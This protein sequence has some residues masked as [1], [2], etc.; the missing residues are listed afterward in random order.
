MFDRLTRRRR[1]V[2]DRGVT[3][4]ELLIAVLITGTLVTAMATATMVII[5]QNDNTEGRVNNARS[6]AAVGI[7]LPSDLASAEEVMTNADA[8]PC[9]ANCPPG[10]F[11]PSS[12]TLMLV[13]HGFVEGDTEPIPTTTSVSY[14]YVQEGDEWQIIRVE[15]Y[16]VGT[17]SPDCVKV[18]VVHDVDPPPAGVEYYPGVTSP[19]WVMLVTLAVDPADTG[20]GEDLEEGEDPTYYIKNGR[21]VTVTINGG[22]DVSGA[23]GGQD[24]I[25]LSAG[26]TNREPDLGT[27]VVSASPTFAA[28]RSRCGGNFGLIVDTSSSIGSNI[29]YVRAGVT[30]FVDAFAGTPVKL[31][32]V[33]F[34]G[35]ASTLGAGSGWSKYYDMLV[36][37]DVIALKAQVAGLSTTNGT[38]WEDGFFRMFR[39]I[40][41]SVQQVLPSTVVFFTDGQP[42]TNRLN[43]T[44]ATG[45]PAVMHNDDIGLPA[46]TGTSYNQMS[47]N[48]ANRVIR[49]FE[50]DLEKF[51]GVYVGTDT[52][53]QSQWRTQGAGYHLEDFT[54]GYHYD[55]QQGYHLGNWER[56]FHTGYQYATTGMTYQYA[57]TGLTYQ[58]ASS[59]VTYQYAG[60]GVLYEQF[61]GGSWVTV[62]GSTFIS[63]NST[64]DASDNWRMTV[65]GTPGSWQSI[66]G[67]SS[68]K[69]SRYDKANTVAGES[70]GIRITTASPGGW[71]TTT[72]S[73]FDL[74][75][76]NSGTSD[77]FRVQIGTLGTWTNTTKAYYDINNTSSAATDG[78]KVVASSPGGW[79]FTTQTYY[80]LNNSTADSSDGFQ[81]ANEYTSPYSAWEATTEVLYNTNNTT[82]DSTDGWR[83]SPVYTAPFP[84]WTATTEGT[85][86]SNNTTA[87]ETDGWRTQNNYSSPY[88][89]WEATTAALYT[90][91]NTAWGTTDGWGATKVY[92][93]P[94][95][96]HEN[97]TTTNRYNRDILAQLI[98]PGGVVNGEPAGGPYTNS[99][100]ATYYVLPQWEQFSG[101][102]TG[103]ALAEC[104]GTVTIQTRVGSAAAADPFTYQNSVDLTTATTSQQFRSGTF[105]F[106]LGGGVSVDAEITQ[107]NLSSNNRYEP[108]SWACTS[109]GA[110]YPFTMTPIDGGPWQEIHLTVSPNTAISCIQTVRLV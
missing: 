36:E 99:A 42:T 49:Q 107:L 64:T 86:N 6:E 47:W 7:W 103:M 94:Y 32:V 63:N 88:G 20:D 110:P 52:N 35:T 2:R 21:R 61:T 101:A 38:N 80:N 9:G 87:D 65:T 81:T 43:G 106:D 12:N 28:T 30:A 40:D 16:V 98:A 85:Y 44:T 77:G 29:S 69:K 27:S 92:E 70:D 109:A 74:S 84:L 10:L 57:G 90:A 62:S 75:N 89:L 82:A 78:Y 23:G 91:N 68:T 25:T 60:S 95:D 22:G 53:G 56:G 18:V 24:Q 73:Y 66:S 55:Y 67:S 50:V 72:K 76:F 39:N 8:S 19:T 26:G 4:P 51:I 105:D 48:R 71:T 97:S 41:G 108:V 58:Y 93:E 15:C 104:G 37:A 5:R 46:A 96:F 100:E 59:G 31:Q 54:R 17:G 83:T 34:A 3:L 45:S 14:R 11:P 13:W 102:M 1:A 79:V 33:R